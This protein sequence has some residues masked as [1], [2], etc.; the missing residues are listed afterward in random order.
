[1]KPRRSGPSQAWMASTGADPRK[2]YDTGNS[3][4]PWDVRRSWKHDKWVV[5]LFRIDPPL[6]HRLTSRRNGPKSHVSEVDLQD[7]DYP[8]DQSLLNH[9]ARFKDLG[10][11]WM[12]GQFIDHYACGTMTRLMTSSHSRRDTYE[13]DRDGEGRIPARYRGPS[14][15]SPRA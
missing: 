11:S 7:P 12:I 3:V 15:R 5:K 14:P 4:L 9:L 2:R 10:Y 13:P 8:V 6:N 1:M